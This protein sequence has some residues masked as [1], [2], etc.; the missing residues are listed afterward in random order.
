MIAQ[1]ST[2]G[3]GLLEMER[4]AETDLAACAIQGLMVVFGFYD[5]GARLITADANVI[6]DLAFGF[7]GFEVFTVLVQAGNAA[8][9][10][11]GDL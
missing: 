6:V 11:V 3:F 2:G 1:G 5:H 4:A 7:D 10:K 8:D 9:A